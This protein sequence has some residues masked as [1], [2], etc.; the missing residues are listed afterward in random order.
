[1]IQRSRMWL[2]GLLHLKKMREPP[3]VLIK[4]I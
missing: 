2:E 4:N 1:M 3:T